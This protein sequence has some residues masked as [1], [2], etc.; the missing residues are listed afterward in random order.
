MAFDVSQFSY[1]EEALNRIF[2]NNKD[3]QAEYEA[4]L[5]SAAQTKQNL[6]GDR[7]S[8]IG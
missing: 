3:A 6:S 5:K 8:E 2:P 4:L 1:I 7:L